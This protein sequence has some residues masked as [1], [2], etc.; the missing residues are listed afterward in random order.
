MVPILTG[1]DRRPVRPADRALFVPVDLLRLDRDLRCAHPVWVALRFPK[2][3]SGPGVGSL[4]TRRLSRPGD[5]LAAARGPLSC[6]IIGPANE[7]RRRCRAKRFEGRLVGV[8][9][10]A[11]RVI[12]VFDI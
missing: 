5:C 1:L 12:M 2:V 6:E 4:L 7:A 10:V 11:G 9:H 8:D 3:A